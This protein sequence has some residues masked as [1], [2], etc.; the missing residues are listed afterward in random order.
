[1]EN[2]GN[3]NM[4]GDASQCPFLSGTQK[5]PAGAGTSNRDWWPNELKLKILRQNASKSNPMI[6]LQR[7]V[8]E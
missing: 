3:L 8:E 7:K 6:I 2:K 5:K 1:M 4:S